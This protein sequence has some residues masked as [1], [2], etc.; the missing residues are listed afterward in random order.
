MLKATIRGAG[1]APGINLLDRAQ[2]APRHDRAQPDPHQILTLAVLRQG[3]GISEAIEEPGFGIRSRRQAL[4]TASSERAD[5][6]RLSRHRRP[7]RPMSLTSRA[8]H[9]ILPPTRAAGD[10]AVG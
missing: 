1:K 8:I 6:G 5:A 9:A 4:V 7:L 3:P 10:G 2:P